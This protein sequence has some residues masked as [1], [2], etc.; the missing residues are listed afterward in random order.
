MPSQM[1]SS[2]AS[3]TSEMISAAYLVAPSAREMLGTPSRRFASRALITFCA[4]S[5]R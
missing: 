4:S 2:E 1:V 5:S 3:S